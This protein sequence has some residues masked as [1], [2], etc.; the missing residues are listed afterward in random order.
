MDLQLARANVQ[1]RL[2]QR[3]DEE[4]DADKYSDDSDEKS[5][6]KRHHLCGD[7]SDCMEKTML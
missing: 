1:R 6:E 3:E 7:C 5:W 2:H 4:D